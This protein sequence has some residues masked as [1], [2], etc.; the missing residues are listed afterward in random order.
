VLITALAGCLGLDKL[1]MPAG[2]PPPDLLLRMAHRKV[3]PSGSLQVF[4]WFAALP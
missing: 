2:S 3:I 1:H 4:Y